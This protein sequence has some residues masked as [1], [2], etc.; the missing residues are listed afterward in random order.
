MVIKSRKCSRYV[1]ML[2]AYLCKMGYPPITVLIDSDRYLNQC[3]RACREKYQ[4][5]FNVVKRDEFLIMKRVS[6]MGMLAS[7]SVF[8]KTTIH[9]HNQGSLSQNLLQYFQREHEFREQSQNISP[10]SLE[11]LA[12]VCSK[13]Q[14]NHPEIVELRHRMHER[15]FWKFIHLYVYS[16]HL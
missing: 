2:H 3:I 12:A 5:G 1:A 16:F 7:D 8:E 4:Y 6:F 10:A 11:S 9:R 15:M 14:L 13:A